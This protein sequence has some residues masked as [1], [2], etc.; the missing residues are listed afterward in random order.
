L[1]AEECYISA[2]EVDGTTFSSRLLPD[3]SRLSPPLGGS[4]RCY[5]LFAPLIF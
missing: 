5:C 1:V 4:E 3:V 2:A